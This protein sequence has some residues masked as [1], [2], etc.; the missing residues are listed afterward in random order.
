MITYYPNCYFKKNEKLKTAGN[1]RLQGLSTFVSELEGGAMLPVRSFSLED[2]TR[3]YILLRKIAKDKNRLLLFSY[4]NFPFFAPTFEGI[5]F[6]KFFLKLFQ[7]AV[8]QHNKKMIIDVYDIPS[9]CAAR[10]KKIGENKK[11]RLFL[12]EK[13]LFEAADVLWA[14][15][16][17][18]AAFIS[19]LYSIDR[20]KFVIAPNGN[21]RRNH[22]LI[23]EKE[24]KVKFVY[25]GNLYWCGVKEMVASFSKLKGEGLELCL[26]GNGYDSIKN[27]LKDPRIKYLG[28]LNHELCEEF[29]RSCNIGILPYD[30]KNRYLDLSH[31]GKLSL[32]ITC[33]I[34]IIATASQTISQIVKN[35]QIGLISD[36]PDMSGAMETLAK[37]H[38]LRKLFSDNCLKIRNNYY[39]DT[40]FNNAL[41]NSLEILN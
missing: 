7:R 16:E 9:F 11:N 38:Q 36:F 35:S 39:F 31:P 12:G 4:P 41:K 18:E 24:P 37:D 13:L 33:G 19:D 29:V 26:M 27:Q 10:L 8:A 3:T 15:S 21:F 5:I 22:P 30:P 14:V 6:L 28:E 40:I 34:P 23:T 20:K 17:A 32:Y 2:F 1:V 25:A